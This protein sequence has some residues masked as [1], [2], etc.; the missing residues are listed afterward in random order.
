MVEAKIKWSKN[1]EIE[2]FEILEFYIQ[3]NKNYAYR[4]SVLKEVTESTVNLL[5]FPML[6]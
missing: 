5:I 2:L 1:V 4:K 6:G 3:R